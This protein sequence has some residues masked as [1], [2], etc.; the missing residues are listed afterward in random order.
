MST[1]KTLTKLRCCGSVMNA[2]FER[3]SPRKLRSAE[4]KRGPHAVNDGES[5]SSPERLEIRVS[6]G[7]RSR[8][9]AP[10]PKTQEISLRSI[11]RPGGGSPQTSYSGE[12]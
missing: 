2:P 12:G 5:R 6:G 10:P 7:R 3:V 8:L 11:G 1:G 9:G 4:H